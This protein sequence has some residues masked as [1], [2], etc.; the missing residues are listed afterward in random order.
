M[1][2]AKLLEERGAK[3][4]WVTKAARRSAQRLSISQVAI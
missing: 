2:C 3:D 4:Y 1:N